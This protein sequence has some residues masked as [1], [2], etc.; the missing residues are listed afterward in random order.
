MPL[1]Q[2]QWQ[3]E[4]IAADKTA[5]AFASVGRRL[6]E[7]Q[8]EAKAAGGMAADMQ[9]LSGAIDFISSGLKGLAGLWVV[10]QVRQY[11][12]S[13]QEATTKIADLAR[14]TGLT[15]DQVQAVQRAARLGGEDFDKLAAYAQSDSEWLDKLSESARRANTVIGTDS[16]KALNDAT[17]A[18]EQAKREAGDL[19]EN[20]NRLTAPT[21]I[22][23]LAQVSGGFKS[24][25][26]SLDLI[27]VNGGAALPTIR[28]IA[29]ILTGGQASRLFGDTADSRAESDL[30]G[31]EAAVVDARKTLSALGPDD[32][33]RGFAQKAIDDAERDLAE[34][35]RRDTQRRARNTATQQDKDSK[36][37]N[38]NI[39]PELGKVPFTGIGS[40]E[41]GF[42][43]TGSAGGGGGE[44]RDRIG[45]NLRMFTE[46]A[47]AA[48][49][50]LEALQKVGKNSVMPLDDLERQVKL[51]KDI[52]DA[53]ATASKYAKDDPRIPQLAEQIRLRESAESAYRKFDAALKQAD[54]TERQYGDGQAARAQQENQ[55]GDARDSGRLS[56]QAYNLAILELGK[57]TEDLRLKNIGLKGGV[58]AFFAGW[59]NAQNQFVRAN[60]AFAQG[61]K[62]FDGIM[63]TMDQALSEFVQNGEINFQ[64]LLTSFALMIVQ[65]EMRA[66]ASQIW[67]AVGG[68]GGILSLLGFGG[69]SVPTLGGDASGFMG[70]SGIMN[71]GVI[72]A[73]GGPV[74]P[75]QAST[76]GDDEIF[77]SNSG[78]NVLNR[79]QQDALGIGGSGPIY[80]TQNISV[81]EYVTATEYRRSI[82][83]VKRAAIE[84]AQE[85]MIARRR[86]GDP[87]IKGVF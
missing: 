29:N 20:W 47:D 26:D 76:M 13:I 80:I 41:M 84:G 75:G 55:L 10:D 54:A 82:A 32:A 27:R 16:V 21:I 85:A 70:G 5:A 33:R 58:D 38:P 34:A 86:R 6:K 71:M 45:E 48:K 44:K 42:G 87:T 49:T 51:E 52:A 69:G 53:I 8:S 81:G 9:K 19:S 28:E 4:L 79:R 60:S 78:G 62:L 59:E 46:Q 25:A 61:G 50:A 43:S 67:G 66:A 35:Q 39:I 73:V 24:M 22:W 15:T 11:V 72:S 37:F 7:V 83:A 68:G 2:A 1:D 63:S 56:V 23:G 12:A 18:S 64:K 17:K 14:Q 3:I 40:G 77:V 57:S 65:M 36:L 30:R 31:R 74:L